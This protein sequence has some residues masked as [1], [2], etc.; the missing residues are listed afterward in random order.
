L[1]GCGNTFEDLSFLFPDRQCK[2]LRP[3]QTPPKM[4]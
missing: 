1:R 3:F 4:P 2:P